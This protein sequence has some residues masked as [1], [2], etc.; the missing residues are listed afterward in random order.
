MFLTSN[1]LADGRDIVCGQI[2]HEENSMTDLYFSYS[3]AIKLFC[4]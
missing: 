4:P 1:F 2:Q 3:L